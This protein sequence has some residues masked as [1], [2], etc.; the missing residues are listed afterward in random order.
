MGADP[1]P[2]ESVERFDGKGAVLCPDA[3]GPEAADLLEVERR[4][5]RGLLETFWTWAG[6]DRYAAQKSGEAW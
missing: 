4:M 6:K 2:Y 5:T 3:D 1:E